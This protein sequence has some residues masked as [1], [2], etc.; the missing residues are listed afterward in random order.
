[1]TGQDG[2]SRRTVAKSLAAAGVTI[3]PR[4]CSAAA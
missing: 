4:T 3:V 1:M 2:W